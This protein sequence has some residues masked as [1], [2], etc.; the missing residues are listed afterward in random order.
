MPLRSTVVASLALVVGIVA[1]AG[2][3]DP[4]AELIALKDGIVAAGGKMDIADFQPPAVADANN[5]APAL[6]KA[7][8]THDRVLD[9]SGWAPAQRP[10]GAPGSDRLDS[11]C[12]YAASTLLDAQ[13][14]MP[15]QPPASPWRCT[16]PTSRSAVSR[17]RR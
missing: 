3:G 11:M 2:C 17:A 15:Y 1:L 9:Y 6:V 4:R 12:F 16:T 10:D 13:P 5:A 14:V 8:S 7:I